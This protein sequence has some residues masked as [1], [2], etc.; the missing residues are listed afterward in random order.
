MGQCSCA[1]GAGWIIL[2]ALQA[3]GC[4]AATWPL[5]GYRLNRRL[6]RIAQLFPAFLFLL[7]VGLLSPAKSHAQQQSQPTSPG[8][9]PAGQV[10]GYTLTP[11][12][13][14]QAVAYARARHELYFLDV[15]YGLL[16]LVLLLHLRVAPK[17]RDLAVRASGN[18][19]VQTIVFAPL[20]LLAVDILNLPTAP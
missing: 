19:F 3:G 11:G 16:L 5:G 18:S 9:S 14:A 8:P 1:R 10:Q 13:E 15:A 4:F 17:F 7:A 6:I 20:F 2:R 12:Q